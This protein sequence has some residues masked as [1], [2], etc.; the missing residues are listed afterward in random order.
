MPDRK[1]HGLRI[2]RSGELDANTPQTP[3]IPQDDPLHSAPG[4]PRAAQF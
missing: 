3:G 2:I 4:K 1:N